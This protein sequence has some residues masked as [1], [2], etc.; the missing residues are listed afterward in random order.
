MAAGSYGTKGK[1]VRGVHTSTHDRPICQERSRRRGRVRVFELVRVRVFEL[2]RVR[3]GGLGALGARSPGGH[4]HRNFTP[5]DTPFETWPAEVDANCKLSRTTMSARREPQRL[6][7]TAPG[8]HTRRR[9]PRTRN[10]VN[11][12]FG[13]ESMGGW[14]LGGRVEE[15]GLGGAKGMEVGW[16]SAASPISHAKESQSPG[17]QV[18]LRR[19]K[20]V[21]R[22]GP[23]PVPSSARPWTSGPSWPRG[24]R[25]R[26]RVRRRRVGRRLHHAGRTSRCRG[27]RRGRRKCAAFSDLVDVDC[28]FL[29]ELPAR[30]RVARGLEVPLD[31]AVK[32]LRRGT[33]HRLLEQSAGRREVS[34]YAT[35]RQP[36]RSY[37]RGRPAERYF[38]RTRRGAFAWRALNLR[39]ERDTPELWAIWAIIPAIT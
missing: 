16:G 14:W 37:V 8:A 3:L 39:A 4:H 34:G 9:R 17:D 32:R 23:S 33:V 10:R 2:V 30:D 28:F 18:H 35:I 22:R 20:C 26:V 15:A 31:P 1:M 11:R 38:T 36:A 6:P 7:S 13:H 27:R 19:R 29:L 5:I 21:R 25:R 24:H 12:R